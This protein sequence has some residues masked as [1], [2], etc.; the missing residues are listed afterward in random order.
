VRC[1]FER[2]EATH[3]SEEV[4]KLGI[5]ETKGRL[6][7]LKRRIMPSDSDGDERAQ[8]K[9]AM[10]DILEGLIVAVSLEPIAGSR[11]ADFSWRLNIDLE[12]RI[13]AVLCKA[14]IWEAVITDPRV[15]AVNTKGREVLRELFHLFLEEVLEKQSVALFPRY[16]R[17]IVE[18]SMRKGV[19]ETARAVCN[20][21]ALMTDMDALRLHSLLRGS[22]PSS[23]FDFI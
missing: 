7:D 3:E 2:Y 23:I 8:R 16:Y 5:E 15:A 20:F 12:S 17:P 18:E 21:L 9:A 22:K 6:A 13:L 4:P 14:I 1:V 10:R 19:D 11:R